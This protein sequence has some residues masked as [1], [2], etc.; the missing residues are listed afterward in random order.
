MK[1][2]KFVNVDP[3]YRTCTLENKLNEAIREINKLKKKITKLSL[4]DA[5]E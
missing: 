2:H 1:E 5:N 4:G 3:Y